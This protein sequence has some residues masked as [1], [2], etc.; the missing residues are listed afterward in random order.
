M[1]SASLVICADDFGMSTAVSQGIAQLAQQGRLQATSVMSLAPGWPTDAA[2]LQ[3]LKGRLDVG[4]H[5]DWTSPFAIAAGHG[6]P[7]PRLMWLA[8]SRQLQSAA[9]RACIERQFDL[10]E[11]HWDAAP[12]HVDG[13]QHV[14]QFPVIREALVDVMAQRYPQGQRPWLRISRPL[15]SGLDLKS[16]VIGAMGAQAL[17]HLAQGAGIPHSRWLTGIYGF[18]G[19]ACAYTRRLG[20]WLS[21]ARDHTGVVLMCHPGLP[22]HAHGDS[23]AG[24]RAQ[25]FEVLQSDELPRF[26]QD[27]GLSTGRGMQPPFDPS[28]PCTPTISP[29]ANPENPG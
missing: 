17:Q 22:G 28:A 15:P 12:D 14:Q 25:E 24:A 7:L 5:L 20:Q 8:L 4:L 16:W 13:H 6:H 21:E 18:D 23:I 27:N 9:V 29:C 11:A 2:L 1:M 26:L 3:P 10:F 19:D